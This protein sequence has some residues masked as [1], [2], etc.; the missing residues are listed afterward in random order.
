MASASSQPVRSI[1]LPAR[2]HPTTLKIEETISK[3]KS[4]ASCCS[5]GA[6][7]IQLGL[8]NLVELYAHVQDLILSFS[9]QQG[10]LVEEALESS[11]LVL[12]TCSQARDVILGFKQQVC[13]LQSALRRKGYSS[14]EKEISMYSSFRKKLAKDVGKCL[15][16]LKQGEGKFGVTAPLLN[17][18][19]PSLVNS[20]RLFREVYSIT[21][22][23]FRSLFTFLSTPTKASGWSLIS[24]LVTKNSG[25]GLK[26][27]R[28]LNEVSRVDLALNDHTK[29]DVMTVRDSIRG[30]DASLQIQEGELGCLYRCLLQNRVSL[31]NILTQ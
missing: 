22:V 16:V 30:L 10:K 19:E 6:E 29:V 9:T 14:F 12:D 5:S 18:I 27:T 25:A 15:K 23:V 2:N 21:V 28:I 26:E 31:L 3:L 7:G 8:L 11:V 17:G 13:D 1:S 24:R 4:R 20:V